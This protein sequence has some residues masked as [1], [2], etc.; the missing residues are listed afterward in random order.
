MSEAIL[1]R[2]MLVSLLVLVQACTPAVPPNEFADAGT[3]GVSE[4]LVFDTW[5]P[6]SCSPNGQPQGSEVRD[7]SLSRRMGIC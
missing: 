3:S 1:R 6:G 2:S 5:V 7:T 4:A